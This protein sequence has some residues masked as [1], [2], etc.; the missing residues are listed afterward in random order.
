M[1]RHATQVFPLEIMARSG[2]MEDEMARRM[3]AYLESAAI[4]KAISL[5]LVVEC[6]KDTIAAWAGWRKAL[7]FRQN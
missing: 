1:I 3:H 5:Q 6:S 7:Y 4:A 2:P